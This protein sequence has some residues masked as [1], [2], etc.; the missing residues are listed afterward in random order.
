M[1]APNPDNMNAMLRVC[2]ISIPD[3]QDIFDTTSNVE[4]LSTDRGEPQNEVEDQ[5]EQEGKI[6]G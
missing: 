4:N 2:P 6:N 1:E 3:S 5:Q